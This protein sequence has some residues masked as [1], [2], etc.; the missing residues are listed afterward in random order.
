MPKKSLW[1]I[2]LIIVF[3]MTVIACT[4]KTDK[5]LNGSWV[6]EGFEIKFNNG[7][8]EEL[9]GEASFRKGD[10]TTN[11]GEIT[12]FPTHIYGEGFN[13]LFDLSEEES[14]VESK[15]YSMNDFIS[16]FKSVLLKLGLSES[17]AEKETDDFVNTLNSTNRVSTY[18]ISGNTL[19][20]TN[21]GTTQSFTRK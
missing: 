1:V 11:N 3:G 19:Y 16:V 17:E 14:G 10:Y 8:F 2:I 15:W 21:E 4:S 12:V 5:A 7:K 20:L 18:N 9:I 13:V 6:S